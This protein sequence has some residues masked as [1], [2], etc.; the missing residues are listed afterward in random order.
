MSEIISFRFGESGTYMGAGF[1]Y[2]Y[3]KTDGKETLIIRIDGVRKEDALKHDA[4]EGFARELFRITEELR[5]HRWDGFDGCDKR[6]LDGRSF[7]FYVTFADGKRI[8]ANGYMKFPKGYGEACNAFDG[9]FL[10]LYEAVRPNRRK[11]M[12]KH[13]E[14]VILRDR[15][16]LEKQEVSYPYVSD[17]GNMYK[18]GVCECTGGAAMY[19][20]YDLKGE[21][22]YLLSLTLDKIDTRWELACEVFGITEKGEVIPSGK[23]LLDA[24]FFNSE[25]LYGH[26]FTR[27]Y[28]DRL[29]LGCFTQK[30]YSA[31]GCDTQYRIVLYGIGNRLEL[32]AD[33][34]TE[35]PAN[36]REW[37]TPDKIANFIA[38]ADRFGFTQSKEYW[39]KA[40][41]DP[42][43]ASGL[44]DNTNHR[45]NFLLT[46]NHDGA[47]YN[48]LINTPKGQRVGEY[49]VKG[50]LYI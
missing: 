24:N 23:A 3:E 35:G 40:P 37:W 10:P 5:L 46:N 30:G 13:F 25:K 45:L 22:S 36:D 17:G 27:I 41:S 29:L 1:D 6:V 20:V 47:F 8:S 31:S 7:H 9:L 26:I 44:K 12:E 48:T 14:E 33:E 32:L 39:E 2:E 15:P 28:E 34:I 42:V 16:R 21:P 50:T 19:P 18:L 4:P 38:V 49:C 43:F 11:V